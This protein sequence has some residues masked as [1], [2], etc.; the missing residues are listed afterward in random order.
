[1]EANDD[2]RWST[3]HFKMGAPAN[4]VL[5]AF[6]VAILLNLLLAKNFL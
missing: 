4:P 6:L 5:K 2:R 3:V 1:M